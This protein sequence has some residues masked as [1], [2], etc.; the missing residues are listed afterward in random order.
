MMTQV[1]KN[2][3]L[4]TKEEEAHK[5]EEEEERLKGYDFMM[6]NVVPTMAIRSESIFTISSPKCKSAARDFFQAKSDHVSSLS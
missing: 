1:T 2:L 3:A 6:A 5:Q 4:S